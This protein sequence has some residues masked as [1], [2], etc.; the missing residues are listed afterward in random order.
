L[1]YEVV[2]GTTSCSNPIRF[3]EDRPFSSKAL[4][5]CYRQGAEAFQTT[6]RSPRADKSSHGR[7]EEAATV[8][9]TREQVNAVR[10]ALKAG[11]KPSV[12]ARQFGLSQSDVRKAL[13]S[14]AG[15]QATQ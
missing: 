5:E 10:A 13:A 8:S 1:G 15:P 4:R 9:L 3:H 14:D 2:V 7:Q 12:I 6:N 11:V